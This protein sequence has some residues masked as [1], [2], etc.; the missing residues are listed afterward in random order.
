MWRVARRAAFDLD[1]FMFVH[2]RSGFFR[3]AR[4][5]NQV[6]R[7]RGPQLPRLESAMLI[8]AIRAFHQPF[9]YPVME[10]PVKLLF[11]VEVTSI[12]Q[13]RLLR[14]QQELALFGVVRIV[15]I[16]TTHPILQVDRTREIPVLFAILMAIEAPRADLLRRSIFK[17][18]N[19][20]LVAPAFDVFLPG[21]V[22]SFAA[23]PF[24]T[25]LLIQHRHVVGGILI[26]LEKTFHRHVF[27]ASLASFRA[28]VE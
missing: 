18:E 12:A 22:A 2:E 27:V 26:A 8:V 23:V 21:S 13:I 14:F 6:L 19:L 17:R 4:K 20:G 25:F 16:G 10:R 9:V 1:G 24:R 7:P 28:D 3:V 5:A 15:A 11:L